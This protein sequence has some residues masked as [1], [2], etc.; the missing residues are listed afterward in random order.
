MAAQTSHQEA[1]LNALASGRCLTMEQLAEATGGMTHRQ[2][3]AACARLIER[4]YMERVEKG[5][6]R[7]T[8]SGLLAHQRGERIT[9]G[10]RGTMERKRPVR[11]SLSTRLWRAMRL[12]KKFTLPALLELSARDEKAAESQAGRYLRGLE[13]T[14]YIHR[15]SRREDGTALTSNG[16]IRWSLINDTGDL[17]PIVRGN[18]TV[19]DPNTNKAMA[20]MTCGEA[21]PC[22]G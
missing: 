5:C 3:S 21:A 6:F 7:A 4:G 18:G 2:I 22:S 10:P 1:I 15:L 9:S 14:G 20:P 11:N 13:K 17:P 12:L 8:G 16:F 19:F